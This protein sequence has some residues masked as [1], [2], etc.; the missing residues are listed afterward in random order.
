MIDTMV[1]KYVNHTV[2]W[3]KT[4]NDH[5]TAHHCE[6]Q[7]E[8]AKEMKDLSSVICVVVKYYD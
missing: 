7:K 3:Y 2:I 5:Y 6:K 4:Y 8:T 1:Y